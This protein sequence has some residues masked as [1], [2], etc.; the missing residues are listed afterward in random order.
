M[1]TVQCVLVITERG[2]TGCNFFIVVLPLAHIPQ[3]FLQLL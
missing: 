3:L 2:G 1:S